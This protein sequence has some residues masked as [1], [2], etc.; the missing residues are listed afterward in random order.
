MAIRRT[1]LRREVREWVARKGARSVV[2]TTFGALA[3]DVPMRSPQEE[4]EA[5][6]EGVAEEVASE[7]LPKR[8]T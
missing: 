4:H 1:E 2:G 5:F 7:G 3:S 6:A 8:S